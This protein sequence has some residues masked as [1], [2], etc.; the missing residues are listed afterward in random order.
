MYSFFDINKLHTGSFVIGIGAGIFTSI[1]IVT[2]LMYIGSFG[3]SEYNNNKNNKN[4][5]KNMKKL[6]RKK[7]KKL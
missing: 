2:G 5:N 3:D 1:G 6:M 7:D 4:N